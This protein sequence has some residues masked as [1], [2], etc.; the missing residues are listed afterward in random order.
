[1][2]TSALVLMLMLAACAGQQPTN[3][4]AG[5]TPEQSWQPLEGTVQVGSSDVQ[6]VVQT[7]VLTFQLSQGRSSGEF[8][9]ITE[10]LVDVEPS[11]EAIR[12]TLKTLDKQVTGEGVGNEISKEARARIEDTIGEVYAVDVNRSTRSGYIFFP[13]EPNGGF[14][15]DAGVDFQTNTILAPNYF[16]GWTIN[17]SQRVA[18]ID[19]ADVLPSL[20]EGN[21]NTVFEGRVA[22]QMER[23][24]RT[25]IVISVSAPGGTRS[26][27][28]QPLG[29]F[30]VDAHTGMVTEGEVA[31]PRMES[32]GG[33]VQISIRV[34]T[35]P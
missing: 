21:S 22:G 13:N 15:Y 3:S 35:K 17:Q 16:G 28:K 29:W 23:A 10:T 20:A 12:I 5:G 1:M 27:P 30:F 6:G 18:A 33:L 2:R 32:G 34:A 11:A 24:G 19:L 25:S 9:A 8:A 4:P 14:A 31:F 7:E 26:N